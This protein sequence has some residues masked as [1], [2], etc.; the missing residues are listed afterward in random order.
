MHRPQPDR[1]LD[2]HA[3]R[4]RA[5]RC[6]RRRVPHVQ[7]P[8]GGAGSGDGTNSGQYDC[9][10]ALPFGQPGGQH[11][12]LRGRDVAAASATGYTLTVAYAPAR[13]GAR[14]VDHDAC[15]RTWHV[16]GYVAMGGGNHRLRL[17]S[18]TIIDRSIPDRLP[19]QTQPSRSEG[20]PRFNANLTPVRRARL[21][22]ARPVNGRALLGRGRRRKST[23]TA[24]SQLES[25]ICWAVVD[26]GS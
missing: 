1:T 13:R 7:S 12:R 25:L 11:L 4:T 10:G 22:H 6:S 17:T 18:A 24:P 23:T 26:S 15:S 8:T 3:R 2:S 14:C 16:D 19:G 5:S 9:G 21:E 20:P